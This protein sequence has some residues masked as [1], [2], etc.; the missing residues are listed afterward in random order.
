MKSRINIYEPN[1]LPLNGGANDVIKLDNAHCIRF[2]D[3]VRLGKNF[4]DKLYPTELA[5]FISSAVNNN[6]NYIFDEVC[7]C[8]HYF[9]VNSVL[10]LS[11]IQ[12]QKGFWD[13]VDVE[14]AM[15]DDIYSR[16][17][18]YNVTH[19]RWTKPQGITV[20][21]LQKLYPEYADK[22]QNAP[23]IEQ[24]FDGAVGCLVSVTGKRVYEFDGNS[25]EYKDFLG[26]WRNLD[27]VDS[28]DDLFKTYLKSDIKKELSGE[29]EIQ[30]EVVSE[31]IKGEIIEPDE[32]TTDKD[33]SYVN[34]LPCS[35]YAILKKP[36]V[37]DY[38]NSG[39]LIS[40]SDKDLFNY[41]VCSEDGYVLITKPD[42]HIINVDIDKFK[43][44]D[45]IEKY[46]TEDCIKAELT[47]CEM[48]DNKIFPLGVVPDLCQGSNC[49]FDIDNCGYVCIGYP[50]PYN[51]EYAHKNYATHSVIVPKETFLSVKEQ[52]VKAY[53]HTSA[54]PRPMQKEEYY[55]SFELNGKSDVEI[56][57]MML[58]YSKDVK[59]SCIFRYADTTISFPWKDYLFYDD[60]MC[61]KH[62]K[63]WKQKNVKTQQKEPNFKNSQKVDNKKNNSKKLK[64]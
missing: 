10:D 7:N 34:D 59:D 22:I 13:R 56:A 18:V 47:A 60:Y 49:Q 19:E 4:A 26:E 43:P 5:A 3:F 35:D 57:S 30:S 48:Y 55:S 9:S 6:Q 38:D 14:N 16:M 1:N 29:S 54:C 61:K 27:L 24:G 44:V 2:Q 63:D 17:G 15:I 51:D 21:E 12:E 32:I 25:H 50:H 8:K 33:Y 31:H 64:I 36:V 52:M 42:G 40:L 45:L 41:V 46:Y 58:N 20:D 28:F 39:Y 62:G 53:A 23:Y 11:A 37:I